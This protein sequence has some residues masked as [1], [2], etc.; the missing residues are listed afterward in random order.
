M[1][2]L[3]KKLQKHW[4]D[5]QM[6]KYRILVVDDELLIRDLLY[7]FFSSQDWDIIVAEGGN[8][9]IEYLKNQNFDIVLTDLKMPDM[10]GMA[11]ASRIR[12]LYR[13]LPVVIMT[14]YPSL[15]SAIEAL[16]YKI[17]DYIIKPFNVNHLFKTIKRVVEETN[18]T[19]QAGEA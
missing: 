11:L 4:L 15:D 6:N 10:D 8:K 14:G 3:L 1:P 19:V 5:R 17:D 13:G 7:D 18:N 16:R 9:A 12:E 2:R